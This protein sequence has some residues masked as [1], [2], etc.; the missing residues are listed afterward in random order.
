MRQNSVVYAHIHTHAYIQHIIVSEVYT[1]M[2]VINTI[3]WCEVF[4]SAENCSRI[5]MRLEGCSHR[6][7]MFSGVF[8]ECTNQTKAM[9]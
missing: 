8:T 6:L 4:L 2:G 5:S 3:C 9:K 7:I 1:D